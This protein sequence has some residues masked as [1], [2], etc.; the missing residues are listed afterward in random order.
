MQPY[1]LLALSGNAKARKV[2]LQYSCILALERRQK[3]KFFRRQKF[4]LLHIK[5]Q[6]KTQNFQGAGY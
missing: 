5:N 3:G 4:A 6:R 2:R 1:L